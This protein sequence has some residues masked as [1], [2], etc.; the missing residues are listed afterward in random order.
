MEMNGGEAAR[1]VRWPFPDGSFPGHLGAVVQRTV[2]SGELPARL[3]IHDDE[4][5]W[6]AG[7]DVNDP[8]VAG[9][10]VIAH[11]THVLGTPPFVNWRPSR[12]DGLPRVPARDSRGTGSRTSTRRSDGAPPLIAARHRSR[13]I[14]RRPCL[15]TATVR[16]G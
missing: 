13:L 14:F 10:S 12:Q 11:M 15:P 3:V 7:D 4:N 1:H 2:L 9:A 6:C 16:Y 5:D 8:D